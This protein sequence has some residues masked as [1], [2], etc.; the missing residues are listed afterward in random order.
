MNLTQIINKIT[1]FVLN[2]LIKEVMEI[3]AFFF[4]GEKISDCF[5]FFLLFNFYISK[6]SY[7][8]DVYLSVTPIQQK[9]RI[10]FNIVYLS[11]SCLLFLYV[12]PGL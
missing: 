4:F 2:I 8:I 12:P 10:S 1:N 6:T 7:K 3:L 11:I 9:N 5:S